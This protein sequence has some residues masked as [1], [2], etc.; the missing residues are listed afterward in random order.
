LEV[1]GEGEKDPHDEERKTNNGAGENIPGPVLPEVVQGVME[2]IF[3][4]L[5]DGRTSFPIIFP[6]NRN[7]ILSPK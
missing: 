7:K 1:I 4:F 5:E 6:L 3:Y 2:K